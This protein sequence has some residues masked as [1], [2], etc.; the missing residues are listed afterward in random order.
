MIWIGQKKRTIIK[1]LNGGGIIK[2]MLISLRKD[3]EEKDHLNAIIYLLN[4][5]ENTSWTL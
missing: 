2:T 3:K 5:I 1:G 4:S